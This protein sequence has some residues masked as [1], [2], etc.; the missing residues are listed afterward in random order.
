MATESE[1]IIGEL[2]TSIFFS[3]FTFNQSCFPAENGELEIADSFILLDDIVFV[4]Q[5]KE[6]N[7][8]AVD[9]VESVDNWFKGK[10]LKKAKNQIKESLRYLKEY[11]GLSIQN[12]RGHAITIPQ[13]EERVI[14]KIIIYLANS[15]NLSNE[16]RNKKFYN[17]QDIG[18]I[19]I[20]ELHDYCFLCDF[21]KT[22]A[23]L[24][25]YLFFRE[26]M[27]EYHRDIINE[28]S[29]QYLLS[30]FLFNPDDLALNRM[31]IELLPKFINDASNFDISNIIENFYERIYQAND[32]APYRYYPIIK[33]LAK[34]SRHSLI[35]F[36]D[37]FS[38][39]INEVHNSSSISLPR[40]FGNL[41]TDCGFV[42]L[43]LGQE[44][45]HLWENA[46]INHTMIFKYK[47][48]YSCCIGIVGYKS[49]EFTDLQW[50][51]I[52]EPWTFNQ[53]LENLV[54]QEKAVYGSGQK[55]ARFYEFNR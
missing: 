20:L 36:K 18:Q 27:G 12:S 53:E 10:V 25:N 22:P 2:N 16:L 6:R 19:N 49:G 8:S 33:E 4:I 42:F 54:E 40:R 48:R 9:T 52:N 23:E 47:H 15:T 5:T 35:D 39:L 46:I 30:H 7:K 45:K 14:R 41:S 17:S 29:E 31:Y 13:I 50:T 44:H 3:E 37:R 21:L 24:N 1:Q 43:P 11:H 38:W 34:L 51:Y 55:V 32:K 26:R 28:Y